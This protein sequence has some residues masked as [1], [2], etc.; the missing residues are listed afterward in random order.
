MRCQQVSEKKKKKKKKN[1]ALTGLTSFDE[2]C[3]CHELFM[4]LGKFALARYVGFLVMFTLT[5]Y[6]CL[7]TE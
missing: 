1:T 2:R 4:V 5:F 7:L 3:D 6:V